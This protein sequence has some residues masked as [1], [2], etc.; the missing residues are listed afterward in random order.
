MATTTTTPT[1][2]VIVVG[3]SFAGLSAAMQLA[4][5]RRR[6][7]VVDAGQPRNRFAAASH[8]FFGQDGE[9]P[10]AMIAQARR[11]LAAY[12]TVTFVQGTVVSATAAVHS[13]QDFAVALQGGEQ[14]AAR[15]LVLAFGVQDGLPEIA[16]LRERWGATVLHCPYCHGYEFAGQRLGV[17]YHSPQSGMHAQLI[18]DWGPTTLF[19]N[20]ETTLDRAEHERLLALGIAVETARIAALEGPGQAL[21]GV[22]LQAAEGGDARVVPLAALYVASATRP[23]S[24]L[25]EQLGCAFDEGPMGPYVRTDA[26]KMTTVPG[27]Y[28]AGDLTL[29][30]HNATLASAEGVLAGTG[31]HQALV[32]G[33]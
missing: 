13:G 9:P 19:L 23:A 12:S 6:V 22:R 14:L 4:R 20:G 32:F 30:R 26:N 33:V 29:M 21:T 11:K 24:P 16:G 25:A 3:G 27:V 2:D 5:A 31:A 18:A 28:A 8:G 1:Y 15:K 7:C 10:L 17:L